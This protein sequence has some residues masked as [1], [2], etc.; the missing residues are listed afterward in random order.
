MCCSI[1]LLPAAFNTVA[2]S[3]RQ[4]CDSKLRRLNSSEHRFPTIHP[5]MIRDARNVSPWT[6]PRECLILLATL[7]RVDAAASKTHSRMSF[8]SACPNPCLHPRYP[9]RPACHR[10][11]APR[12]P[13]RRAPAR[14]SHARPGRVGDESRGQRDQGAPPT[15]RPGVDPG[16]SAH[17]ARARRRDTRKDDADRVRASASHAPRKRQPRPRGRRPLSERPPPSTAGPRGRALS[18]G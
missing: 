7:V 18:L 4:F 10:S 6:V 17:A 13:R 12:R 14:A 3:P 5:R 2:S 9:L 11:Y 8:G 15:R 1:L 16:A